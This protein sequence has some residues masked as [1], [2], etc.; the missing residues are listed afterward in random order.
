[1]R[2]SQEQERRL[3]EAVENLSG[4]LTRVAA[5]N[6]SVQVDRD[7]SGD[8]ADVLA[9]LV[10]NTIAELGILVTATQRK[11]DEDRVRLEALVQERTRE[12]ALMA[13][14]DLVTEVFNRSRLVELGRDEI[15]RASR[16]NLPLSLAILDLDHFKIVND[17]FGHAVGDAALRFAA[18][19][20]RSRVRASDHVGRWGGEEFVVLIIDTGRAGA[21]TLADDVREAIEEARLSLNGQSITL[22]ASVG[23]AEWQRGETL[24]DVLGRADVALYQAKEAGRNRVVAAENP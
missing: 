16:N 18:N 2:A 20:I 19:A 23:V 24:D 4:A 12:L 9:Y 10:N 21:L 8:S 17:T 1:M 5:G 6:F 15:Q 11:A 13:T 7:F 3:A 14:R 22:S